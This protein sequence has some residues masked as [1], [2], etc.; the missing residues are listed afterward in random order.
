MHISLEYR[1]DVVSFTVQT[2]YAC[3][4]SE[5]LAAMQAEYDVK[6]SELQQQQKQLEQQVQM[7]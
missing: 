2:S 3:T 7:F 4:Q 1:T 6:Y 5:R